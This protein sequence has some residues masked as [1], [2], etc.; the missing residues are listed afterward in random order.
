MNFLKSYYK[1]IG[2]SLVIAYLC[3]A[4]ANEFKKVHISIPHFDKV[5]H[6]GMFFILAMFIGAINTKSKNIGFWLGL[7]LLAAL[8]GG[9]I[10]II[11]WKFIFM[12]NG[13]WFD[14]LADLLGIIIGIYAIDL[15]PQKIKQ[16]LK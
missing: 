15:I 1:I 16:L 9:I 5:V 11:Q 4:P 14:W 12:R 13:D 8:Y 7:P 6:F 3:F 2:W 10:E